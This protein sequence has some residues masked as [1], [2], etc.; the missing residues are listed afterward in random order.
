MKKLELRILH[1]ETLLGKEQKPQK[2]DIVTRIVEVKSQLDL[3]EYDLD[4]EKFVQRIIQSRPLLKETDKLKTQQLSMGKKT[5]N[6]GIYKNYLQKQLK[7]VEIIE[8]EKKF[9]DFPPIN[10]LKEKQSILRPI[11]EISCENLEKFKEEDHEINGLMK[12]YDDCVKKMNEKFLY[13]D[14]L[15]TKAEEK[16]KGNK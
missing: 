1:L 12:E 4:Y 13:L 11:Q 2:N 7:R 16:K 3:F 6:I 15:L 14:C 8:K 10:D 5:K 9:L